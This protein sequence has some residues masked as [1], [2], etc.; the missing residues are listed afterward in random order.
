MPLVRSVESRDF[1]AIV[2]LA[3]L[4]LAAMVPARAAG[5]FPFGE[6]LLLDTRPI[7]PG[8]RM[9]SITVE[10]SGN[11]MLDLW[12]R[13]VTGRVEV[14]EGT[15]RIAAEPLPEQLPAMQGSGQCTPERIRADE[16]LLAALTQATSWRAAGRTVVLEGAASMK[17]RAATN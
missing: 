7:R 14:A 13:S 15:I 3:A 2:V 11:A 10:R 4:V 8:K 12:C 5:E 16:D 9:P 17:F 6:E 1:V